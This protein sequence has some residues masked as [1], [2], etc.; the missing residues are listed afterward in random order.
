MPRTLAP[1]AIT[2][3]IDE[4]IE[5]YRLKTGSSISQIQRDAL[6]AWIEK[7]KRKNK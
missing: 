5:Q 7:D 1:L 6:M 3:Y 2:K 4:Y